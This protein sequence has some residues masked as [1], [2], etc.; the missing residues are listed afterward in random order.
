M[1][2]CCIPR[3]VRRQWVNCK[4]Y[5]ACLARGRMPCGQAFFWTTD[6]MRPGLRLYIARPLTGR[7][8]QIRVAMKSNGVPVLGDIRA[9]LSMHKVTVTRHHAVWCPSNDKIHKC[10]FK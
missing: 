2:K 3:L 10:G 4:A 6:A 5:K 1:V 8:H 7:T 9:G